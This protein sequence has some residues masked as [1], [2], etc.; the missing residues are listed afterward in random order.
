[1]NEWSNGLFRRTAEH[2]MSD[3][4]VRECQLESYPALANKLSWDS[5]RDLIREGGCSF[6]G[7]VYREKR[8]STYTNEKTQTMVNVNAS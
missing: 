6:E 8:L 3:L 5:E 4:S 7:V 1:M 2:R